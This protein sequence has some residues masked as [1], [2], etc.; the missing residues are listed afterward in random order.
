VK[1]PADFKTIPTFPDEQAVGLSGRKG[2]FFYSRN[3]ICI[4]KKIVK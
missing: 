4:L 2:M 1:C 3:R